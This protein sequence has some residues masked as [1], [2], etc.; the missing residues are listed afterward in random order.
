MGRHVLKRGLPTEIKGSKKSLNKMQS[1][2][3]EGQRGERAVSGMTGSLFHSKGDISLNKTGKRR[4]KFQKA[5]VHRYG[6]AERTRS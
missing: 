1:V 6:K 5:S 2:P 3:N 4:E